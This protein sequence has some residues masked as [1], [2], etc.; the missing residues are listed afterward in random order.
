MHCKSPGL[1]PACKRNWPWQAI[2]LA[3]WAVLLLPG[4]LQAEPPA[5]FSASYEARFGGFKAEAERAMEFIDAEN[6]HMSTSMELKLLGQTV[7]RI[8]ETSAIHIDHEND[9]TRSNQ[10]SFIQT[11]IG[12]RQRHI[13]FEWDDAIARA[14]LDKLTVDL[15]LEGN[16]R[17][18][19][20]A[21]LEIRKQLFAGNTEI[22][23]PGIYKG[24]LE[25]IHYR[26]A[27]EEH[28]TTELGTFNAVRLQR[29]REPGSDRTTD[30][31]LAPDWD[32]LLI[33]LIQDEPGSSTISLELREANVNN[34]TVTPIAIQDQ[35]QN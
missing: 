25:E 13:N 28:V 8:Q 31:W 10:Y 23:F 14:K 33:K 12:K 9:L 34:E 3:L 1:Q 22:I 20:S 2:V 26:V 17:D 7:S 18:T 11:G 24:E 29:I 27:G 4:L 16:V 15:P 19:L 5:P 35:Q 32:Y 30:I 6:I 21:Y